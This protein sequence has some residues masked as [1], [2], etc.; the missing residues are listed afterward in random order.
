MFFLTVYPDNYKSA[1]YEDFRGIAVKH[2]SF[3]SLAAAERHYQRIGQGRSAEIHSLTVDGLVL[4]ECYR[5]RE[6]AGS[7]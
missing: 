5:A 6:S 1:T 7:A 3:P 4:V 2:G